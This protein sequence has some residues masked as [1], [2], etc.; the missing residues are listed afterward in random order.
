M[1]YWRFRFLLGGLTG[2]K[3]NAWLHLV[4]GW[5]ECLSRKQRMNLNGISHPVAI[6]QLKIYADRLHGHTRLIYISISGNWKYP[7]WDSFLCGNF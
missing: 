5:W 7:I 2:D 4:E 3:G 1:F 6:S